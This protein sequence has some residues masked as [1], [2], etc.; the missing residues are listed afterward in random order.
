MDLEKSVQAYVN[1]SLALSVIRYSSFN[2]LHVFAANHLPH[3][4]D[5]INN[6]WQYDTNNLEDWR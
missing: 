6:F 4:T 2:S 1:P 5:N 3:L